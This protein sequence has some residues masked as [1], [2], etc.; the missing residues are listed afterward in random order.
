MTLEFEK[1]VPA[2]AD[3]VQQ[4]S[5]RRQQQSRQLYEAQARLNRH[6]SSW[7]LLNSAIDKAIE[8]GD[9]K[10]FRAARPLHHSYPLNK[11]VNPAAPPSQATII[12]CDGSQIV[13]DRHAPFLYYLINIGLIVYYHGSGISPDIFS[14][15]ILKYPGSDE[16]D[17]EDTFSLQSAAVS[18]RRDQLEIEALSQALKQVREMPGPKLAIMDQRLL[19]WPAG[20]LPDRESHKVVEAWQASMSE[21]RQSGA[22]LAGFIDRPGKRSVLTMLHTL[23]IHKPVF[24]VND[25]Y[26]AP[27]FNHLADIDLFALLLDVGQRSPVFVDISQH[28]SSFRAREP[29]NEVCFFYLRTGHGERQL[30][31]VDI[32]MWVA[33]DEQNVNALHA[34]IYDQCQILGNYPYVITR[35]DEIAVV[36]RRDQEELEHRIA[37]RLAEQGLNAVSTSKQQSKQ[38]ARSGKTRHERI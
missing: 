37:L 38:Y 15:P 4:T 22:W 25:L 34:L 12:A 7:E 30:A 5:Q 36:G 26:H 21:I 6:A 24:R 35:A 19:Y 10:Y 11:G 1:L 31:R 18:L 14:D 28:N 17:E 16:I 33:R 13:P 29:E 32:P 27:M 23:D 8:K 3:M 9:Q 2:V 20:G